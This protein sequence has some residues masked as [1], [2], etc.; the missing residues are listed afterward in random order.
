MVLS[1]A[2][3]YGA[4]CMSMTGSDNPCASFHFLETDGING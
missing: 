3:P 2:S 1:M 4:V